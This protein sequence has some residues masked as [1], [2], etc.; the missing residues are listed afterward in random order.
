L[1]DED[2][3]RDLLAESC[4]AINSVKVRPILV[5]SPVSSIWG[6]VTLY[7]VAFGV[8]WLSYPYVSTRFSAAV[9]VVAGTRYGGYVELSE[10]DVDLSF[11]GGKLD[12]SIGFEDA[13]IRLVHG[14]RMGN[15]PKS[16]LV[17]SIGLPTLV[18]PRSNRWDGSP[19]A[20]YC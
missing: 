17:E 12:I 1:V 5:G 7:R 18:G 13:R 11:E 4:L 10:E 2:L 8:D 20:F 16:T 19:R 14:D 3:L 15:L 6:Y 9:A